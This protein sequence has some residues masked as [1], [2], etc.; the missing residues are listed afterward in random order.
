[1]LPRDV[2]KVVKASGKVYYYYAPRRGA[3]GAGKRIALGSDTSDPEFWRKLRE[4]ST[5][6]AASN[7]TLS[8]LIAEY[9]AHK[10]FAD[11][12][13]E[14]KRV[15]AHF[16]DRLEAGGGDRSVAAMT[17]RDIYALLENSQAV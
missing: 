5:P 9:R 4:A 6:V 7:G 12:R 14:S 17:R 3:K 2:Q 8:K 1:M 16:L 11:L 15:Y 10:E 13:P